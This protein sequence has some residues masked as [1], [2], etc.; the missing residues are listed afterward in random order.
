VIVNLFGQVR[1]LVTS[2]WV[3]VTLPRQLSVTRPPARLKL[4]GRS[5]QEGPSTRTERPPLP[6]KWRLAQWY[7]RR[8]CAECKRRNCR[9]RR[10]RSR[11]GQHLACRCNCRRGRVAVGESSTGAAQLS[12]AVADPVFEMSVEVPHCSCLSAGQVM[13][14]AV[15]SFTVIVWVHVD[16]RRRCQSRPWCVYHIVAA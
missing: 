9:K 3:T 16:C 13:T 7:R 15:V 5:P 14:G 1:L 6:G 2:V 12:V 11:S 4:A 8:R 10:W